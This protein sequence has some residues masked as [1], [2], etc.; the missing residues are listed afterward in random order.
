MELD[1]TYPEP[2]DYDE[3]TTL[4]FVKLK[5]EELYEVHRAKDSNALKILQ[6]ANSKNAM[7]EY[8]SELANTIRMLDSEQAAS[9]LERL[10]EDC[11][12]DRMVRFI[13]T[14]RIGFNNKMTSDY[15]NN[16]DTVLEAIAP[17][18][19][20]RELWIKLKKFV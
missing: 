12:M 16:C 2:L 14:L 3:E 8:M 15:Q 13:F 6:D 1:A 10:Q 9:L 7:L 17:R 5:L 18:S 4:M 11:E 19:S 20:H